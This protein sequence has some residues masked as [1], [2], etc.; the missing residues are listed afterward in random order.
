MA[1]RFTGVAEQVDRRK[2][3]HDADQGGE[4]DQPEIVSVRDTIIDLQH[5]HTVAA[6]IPQCGIGMG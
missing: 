1:A 5:H 3:R 6:E 4:A 2:G